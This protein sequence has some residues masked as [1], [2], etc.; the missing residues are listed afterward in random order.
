MQIKKRHQDLEAHPNDVCLCENWCK[1]Q[2]LHKM[3][4][5][6]RLLKVY[7]YFY[8]TAIF[9]SFVSQKALN[10]EDYASNTVFPWTLRAAGGAPGS[11]APHQHTNRS[12]VPPQTS[13]AAKTSQHAQHLLCPVRLWYFCRRM[14]LVSMKQN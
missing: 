14:H 10:Q 2:N 13:A 1:Y 8:L 11:L 12:Q 4:S 5:P 3:Y 9:F 7:T 6:S